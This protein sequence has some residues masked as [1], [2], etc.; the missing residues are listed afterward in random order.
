MQQL[1]DPNIDEREQAV[2]PSGSNYDLDFD[3]LLDEDLEPLESLH[4]KQIIQL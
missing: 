3:N 4:Q 1:Q 2:I